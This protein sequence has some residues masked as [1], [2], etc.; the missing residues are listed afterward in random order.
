MA[1]QQVEGGANLLDVCMDEGMLDSA[2]AMRRFLNLVSADP[3]I[4]R[5]PIMIDSSRWD[6]L[7]TGLQGLQGKAVVNS[8]SLKDGEAAFRRA[9]AEGPPVRRG[10]R[11][12]G[13]RR[14]GA[15][16][17]GREEGRGLPSARTGS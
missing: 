4:A 14:G 13:L 3:D 6:V 1:R 11:R 2:A 9:G 15:G 17:D 10:R 16:G 5:L 7:E 8:L 12:H